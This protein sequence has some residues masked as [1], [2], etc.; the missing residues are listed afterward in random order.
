MTDVLTAH[1]RAIIGAN[2]YLVLGTTDPDGHPWASPVYFAA[3]GDR[4]FYWLSATDA[5]HSRH[6]A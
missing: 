4:T 3:D 6:L 5:E 2:R 1:A